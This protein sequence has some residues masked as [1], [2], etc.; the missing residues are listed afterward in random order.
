MN[1]HESRNLSAWRNP[2]ILNI[3]YGIP[4]F[5]LHLCTDWVWRQSTSSWAT[6]LTFEIPPPP[7][8]PSLQLK[9]LPGWLSTWQEAYKFGSKVH[10]SIISSPSVLQSSVVGIETLSKWI[11][12]VYWIQP[13]QNSLSN[14]LI[15]ERRFVLNIVEAQVVF[16][17]QVLCSLA[18]EISWFKSE[19][20]SFPFCL[21]DSSP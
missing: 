20:L 2:Q 17:M 13:E 15:L 11:G 19:S 1:H 21:S 14:V 9:M 16:Q 4:K 10:L 18:S 5:E 3:T 12:I 8:P 6:F 7:E